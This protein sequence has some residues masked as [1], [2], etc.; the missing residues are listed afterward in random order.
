MRARWLASIAPNPCAS[1]EKRWHR[2]A[3]VALFIDAH[4]WNTKVV[5]IF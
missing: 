3:M 2:A 5:Q 4:S 1:G